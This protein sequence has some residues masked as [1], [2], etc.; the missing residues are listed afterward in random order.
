MG[1]WRA[2]I[3]LFFLGVAKLGM[4]A[5]SLMQDWMPTDF[6]GTPALS[7]SSGSQWVPL[8]QMNLGF[9]TEPVWLRFSVKNPYD[10]P[11]HRLF[12]VDNPRLQAVDLY[13]FEQEHWHRWMHQEAEGS[14]KDRGFVFNLTWKPHRQET[15]YFRIV[16][17]HQLILP[18]KLLR[19]NEFSQVQIRRTWYQGFFYGAMLGL[20]LTNFLSWMISREKLLLWLVVTQLPLLGMLLDAEAVLATWWLRNPLQEINI[21]VWLSLAS[22]IMPLFARYYLGLRNL[23]LVNRLLQGLSWLSVLLCLPA[24]AGN[25]H[26]LRVLILLLMLLNLTL[27]PVQVFW[28][29][30]QQKKMAHYYLLSW[31]VYFLVS[32]V[33]MLLLSGWLPEEFTWINTFKWLVLPS[34]VLVTL[35]VGIRIQEVQRKRQIAEHNT[36]R[37]ETQNLAKSEFLTTISHEIRAPMN[38]VL[39][40]IELMRVSGLSEDQQKLVSSLTAS[41]EGLLKIISDIYDYSAME[42]GQLSLDLAEFDL[43]ALLVEVMSLFKS[44]A[45][46]K[47]LLLLGSVSAKTPVRVIGDP[48]RLRQ[49]LV[50]LLS[51]AV[52]HTEQGRIDLMVSSRRVSKGIRLEFAVKDTG[53]GISPERQER[54]FEMLS[55]EARDG[56]PGVGL[57][58]AVCKR[59]SRLMGGD[60]SVESHMYQGSTFSFWVEMGVALMPVAIMDW[61]SGVVCRLLLVDQDLEYLELMSR[62][63]AVP[64][65]TLDT[66]ISLADCR[67]KLALAEQSGQPY[68]LVVAA[69]QMEDGNS[70]ELRSVIDA[71]PLHKNTQ[72]AVTTMPYWQPNPGV[73]R[74]A[75]IVLAAERP[76][77]AYELRQIVASLLLKEK[78][79]QFWERHQE[80]FKGWRVLVAENHVGHQRVTSTM[81][82]R[83][84]LI[85][86]VVT[87]GLEACRLI[88]QAET[89]FDLILM[90]CNLPGCDGIEAT[91]RIRT[92]ELERGHR[93]VPVLALTTEISEVELQKCYSAGM[94]DF[95]KKPV[96]ITELK[97]KLEHWLD[98]QVAPE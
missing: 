32:D 78:S 19:P 96:S 79:Q 65:M 36:V 3:V 2:L 71:L 37:A 22:A 39:N 81:L 88:N 59:L 41:G 82:R 18:L 75:G 11:L 93:R 85:P 86:E 13:V 6:I 5:G 51:N 76:V 17:S 50:N 23:Q 64:D 34:S 16:A 98:V 38:E 95:L 47:G 1:F 80:R 61:P 72:L 60:I 43:Q 31:I 49:V 68:T 52:R 15:W 62:E 63:A 84:G 12:L 91:R 77:M 46:K 83:L 69:L 8:Q 45:Y 24:M 94:S 44:A 20:W 70:L 73:L 33:F 14:A 53:L 21:L 92:R 58:L 90:D 89:P 67:H 26:W 97:A 42:S 55:V 25:W 30:Q 87:D 40:I 74:Q 27:L 10:H 4:A 29:Y 48:L 7:V 57:G 66:A 28:S 35:G 54:L 56:T 9:H